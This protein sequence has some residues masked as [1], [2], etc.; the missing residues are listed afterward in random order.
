MF[1]FAAVPAGIQFVAFF[2]L[3]ESPRWLYEHGLKEDAREVYRKRSNLSIAYIQVLD[4]IYNG[5]RQWIDYELNEIA[6][7]HEAVT[8]DHKSG[9]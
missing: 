8:K 5:D 6:M 2:C 1:G 7:A 9:A 3:P 4:K